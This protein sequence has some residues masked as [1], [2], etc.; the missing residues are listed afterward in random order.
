[1]RV[2]L[3][4]F[5]CHSD[6]KTQIFGIAHSSTELIL[7]LWDNKGIR[8]DFEATSSP[9]HVLL[10]CQ[11]L[12]CVDYLFQFQIRMVLKLD[13]EMKVFKIMLRL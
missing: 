5:G 12:L 9:F 6:L 11:Q 10:V 1:M 13:S 8:V 2:S 7:F 4:I 3:P